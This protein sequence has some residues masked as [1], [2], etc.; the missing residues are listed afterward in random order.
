VALMPGL[1]EPDCL[2]NCLGPEHVAYAAGWAAVHSSELVHLRVLR[3]GNEAFAD[4]EQQE[5]P[6]VPSTFDKC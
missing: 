5:R 3:L 2:Q 6:L 1:H 4:L